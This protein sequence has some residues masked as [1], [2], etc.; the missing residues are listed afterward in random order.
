MGLNGI[1]WDWMGLDGMDSV[2]SSNRLP[3]LGKI[4]KIIRRI[5]RK[6][7]KNLPVGTARVIRFAKTRALRRARQL[8][9]SLGGVM[10]KRQRDYEKL[11][12]RSYWEC[13]VYH[14][15]LTT[16]DVKF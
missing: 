15:I 3:W 4:W 16:K 13:I 2:S 11:S 12:L 7:W 10:A 1:G 9:T 8:S 6:I 14:Q 5:I